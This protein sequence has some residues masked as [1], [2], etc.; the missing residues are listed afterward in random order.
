MVDPLTMLD[1]TIESLNIVPILS[2][3]YEVLDKTS[4]PQVDIEL[5]G[6]W[7][8][9]NCLGIDRFEIKKWNSTRSLQHD[10]SSVEAE[11]MQ[12]CMI[13]ECSR[14]RY[15]SDN[16]PRC[17]SGPGTNSHGGPEPSTLV[18]AGPVVTTLDAQWEHSGNFKLCVV[19]TSTNNKTTSSIRVLET[20]KND[21]SLDG[22]YQDTA[23]AQNS[24]LNECVIKNF[25]PQLTKRKPPGSQ[26]LDQ[27]W[28]IPELRCS[29]RENSTV[30][31]VF[32]DPSPDKEPQNNKKQFRLNY[33]LAI[34]N[35][36]M[37]PGGTSPMELTNQTWS[38]VPMNYDWSLYH[39]Y[40]KCHQPFF[41]I[42]LTWK[43]VFVRIPSYTIVTL[44][45]V[46]SLITFMSSTLSILA[47]FFSQNPI[48]IAK[49]DSLKHG[50][51]FQLNYHLN[52]QQLRTGHLIL[53]YEDCTDPFCPGGGSPAVIGW[54]N[55]ITSS[56]DDLEH[57][58]LHISGF[59]NIVVKLHAPW[60]MTDAPCPGV[61]RESSCMNEHD[62]MRGQPSLDN[63]FVGM[64]SVLSRT[65][66]PTHPVNMQNTLPQ[67]RL[68][69]LSPSLE[70]ML[71]A[72]QLKDVDG[73]ALVCLCHPYTHSILTLMGSYIID[74][75]LRSSQLSCANLGSCNLKFFAYVIDCVYIPSCLV[76][77][78]K[79]NS[80][81]FIL[82][83]ASCKKLNNR[84]D[85]SK[86]WD[87]G[88]SSLMGMFS[89]QM[90]TCGS[91]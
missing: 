60:K 78:S 85:N 91:D 69:E 67:Q 19:M 42:N 21:M 81:V 9:S 89:T 10:V 80:E 12:P 41:V 28:G 37:L 73:K 11:S 36:L 63:S 2:N 62:C 27:N 61:M 23:A 16:H 14:K 13:G 52:F 57:V 15:F 59:D 25:G 7:K 68:M 75:G 51:H 33:D 26:M 46:V 29:E 47:P 18:T 84:K 31:E 34:R 72:T 44:L 77:Y 71:A 43:F 56:L 65:L 53:M 17:S 40:F 70:L 79:L 35:W 86:R 48:V 1:S 55:T 49:V 87:R 45:T 66:Y 32:M 3:R 39:V 24:P 30:W 38:W 6:Q 5:G 20:L 83:L 76:H 22:N 50:L 74:D 8:C 64:A 54:I 90:K 4:E 58:I 82:N 88:I